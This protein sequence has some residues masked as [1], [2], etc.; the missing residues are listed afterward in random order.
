MT[1][2]RIGYGAGPQQLIAAMAKLQSHLSGGVSAISQFAAT[3]ALR[4]D[5]VLL[6]DRV[7]QYRMRRDLVTKRLRAC[8]A[9]RVIEPR[10]AFYVFVQILDPCRLGGR[11]V[12]DFLLDYGVAVIAGQAFGAPGWFRISIATDAHTLERAC[13]GIRAA[14]G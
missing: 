8:T 5:P 14:F 10:G 7:A 6:R 4:S 1:G 9:L 3:A 11:P 2:W 13:V 12:D